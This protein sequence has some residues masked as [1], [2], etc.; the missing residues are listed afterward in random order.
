MPW[1]HLFIAGLLEVTW[2][3][4]LKWSEGFTNFAPT[5][6]TTAFTLISFY[7]L[8]QAMK[9]IPIGTTYAVLAGIGA[10]GTVIAGILL[11]GED[12]QFV[13]IVC[14]ALIVVGVVGLRAF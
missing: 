6:A 9:A 5:A 13:H 7:F 2:A 1:V 4:T 12:Y 8:S 14:I 10:V 3:V 11:F